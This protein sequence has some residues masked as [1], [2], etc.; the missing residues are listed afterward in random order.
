MVIALPILTLALVVILG[1]LVG[2]VLEEIYLRARYGRWR[3]RSLPL[4][5]TSGTLP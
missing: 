4:R 2:G 5:S 1:L 3:G